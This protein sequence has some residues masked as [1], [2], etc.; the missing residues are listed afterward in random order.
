MVRIAVLMV[1][2]SLLPMATFQAGSA[3]ADTSSSTIV[4]KSEEVLHSFKGY[5]LSKK[6]EAVSHG[7][8][9]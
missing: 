5:L 3:I 1:V 7:E 4:Q 2:M 8:T 9:L 6:K